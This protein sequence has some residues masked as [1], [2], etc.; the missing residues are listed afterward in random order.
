ML[1]NS[2]SHIVIHGW[3]VNGEELDLKGNDLL[4]YAIIYGFSQADD[5]YFKGSLQYLADW[6]GSTKQGIQK[7][8]KN[9][10]DKGLIE[11]KE[12]YINGVKFCHYRSC[13]VCNK[14]VQG[15]QQSS[16][17]GIQLSCTNNIDIDNIDNNIDLSIKKNIKKKDSDIDYTNKEQNS[18]VAEIVIYLNQRAWT[19][20]KV[21]TPKTQRLIRARLNE[22]FT[23][24]D[25]KAVIDKKCDEWLYTDMA[26]YLRPETLFGT[27]FE[28]YLN[29]KNKQSKKE[30]SLFERIAKGEVTINYDSTG[31]GDNTDDVTS[32]LSLPF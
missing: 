6:T 27:K 7:N 20:Y 32:E 14:V 15:I 26:K 30:G 9:L 10:I 25:F 13:L 22:G 4:V 1:V 2:K 16:P 8:I 17:G 31:D 21:H 28:G 11:K 19:N 18:Q 23:V 3:M 29:Q 12:V 24:D 5:Q